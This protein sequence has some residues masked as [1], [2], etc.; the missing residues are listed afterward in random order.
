MRVHE[1]A[2]IAVAVIVLAPAAAFAAGGHDSVGCTGCHSI[3]SAKGR[4]IFAVAPNTKYLNPK[5][6]QPYGGSTGL[7]LACHQ[8]SEKGGQ[9]YAPVSQHMSHPFSAASVSSKVARVPAQ[10]LREN[11]RFECISCH[12]PHPSNPHAKYL[13]ADV[14]PNGER[15]DR[16]C[17]VC[18]GSK[19]DPS[20]A[21]APLFTSMD[22]T[23]PRSAPQ[24]SPAPGPGAGGGKS[25][26]G[27]TG[28]GGKGR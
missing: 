7:C 24:A 28:N 18:H 13:R 26:A 6:N 2:R 27:R 15:L 1:A 17:G 21:N 10:L 5:T 16:F 9:G 25:G 12:D 19:A 3:H 11:G 20:A 8:D 22:E 4:L 23:A 14:G